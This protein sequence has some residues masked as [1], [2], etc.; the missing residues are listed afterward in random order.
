MPS[1][2]APCL[3]G[4]SLSCLLGCNPVS[5]LFTVLRMV[6]SFGFAISLIA[7]L[8]NAALF[9]FELWTLF[10]VPLTCAF[11][12]CHVHFSTSW[13]SQPSTLGGNDF[14]R[15][16]RGLLPSNS[17]DNRLHVRVTKS[18]SAFSPVSCGRGR[19]KPYVLLLF[20]AT[21]GF[22]GEGPISCLN[23]PL[24]YW[25]ISTLYRESQNLFLLE[26]NG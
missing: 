11:A 17:I 12:I 10:N 4:F 3:F 23:D 5:W 25:S 15:R 22:P 20:N 8:L 6:P 18:D 1:V 2:F 9:V 19:R 13:P 7:L 21:L 26:G 16:V 24:K 14:C